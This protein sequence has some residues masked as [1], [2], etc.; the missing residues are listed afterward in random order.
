MFPF[1]VI[2]VK[3]KCSAMVTK[4]TLIGPFVLVRIVFLSLINK[5]LESLCPH[6]RKPLGLQNLELWMSVFNTP[7][8]L[9]DNVLIALMNFA[10]VEVI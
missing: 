6:L 7:I 3:Q 2:G 1:D 8:F 5:T 9:P 10:C 4:T